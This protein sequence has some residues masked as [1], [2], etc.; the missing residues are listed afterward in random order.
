MR[1]FAAALIFFGVAASYAQTP[2]VPHKMD[3]AGMTLT[4]RDDARK[5]IQTD[6]DAL[7]RS[8]KHFNMKVERA[9]TYFPFIEK[10]FAEEKLPDDFK[11]LALQESALIADAVSV[12]NAVGFWQFKDFTAMEMGMRVDKEIDERMNLISASRGAAKYLKKNNN[13]FDNWL[14]ALQS[15]QMGA[16]GVQRSIGDKYNGS[17][18]MEITSET[19]WY[20]KKYLAHKV[21]FEAAMKGDAQLKVMDYQPNSSTSLS[22]VAKLLSIDEAKLIEY[23]KWARKGNIPDDR[24]YTLLVPIGDSDADFTKLALSKAPTEPAVTVKETKTTVVEAP[25][26]INGVA[27]IKAQKGELLAALASRANVDVTDFAKYNDISIDHHVKSGAYY[28]VDKKKTKASE[29]FHQ[30][31]QGEDL[32]AVSQKYGVQLRK[33]L[34]YNRV[35]ASAAVVAGT[36][37]WLAGKMP[38]NSGSEAAKSTADAVEVSDEDTFEWNTEAPVASVKKEVTISPS[39]PVEILETIQTTP[40]IEMATDPSGQDTIH[41]V[42]PKETL[43]SIAK[44]YAVSVGDLA[45]WNSLDL[46][47]GIHPGQSLQV[48]ANALPLPQ[49]GAEPVIVKETEP[50]VVQAA[51]VNNQFH[52]VKTSDT[53]Y[54]VARQ[55]GV[56]IKELM[57]WN[58]KTDFSLAVGEKLKVSGK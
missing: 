34:K 18:H 21:A 55:Y 16:G 44:M 8:P 1:F 41:I 39:K 10:I 14:L 2:E 45:Q 13:F 30:L 52:E 4:I 42:Q 43:Y 32:W 40:I 38:K 36:Q 6:V 47:K 9:R 27:T 53:L 15:Y 54:S 3:F 48:F 37:I 7:T 19:Y 5:E 35:D 22:D 20:V 51:I 17:R 28:F 46:Q 33:L 24:K 58:S 29:P 49:S 11:Y 26:L 57:D 25:F 50:V 12:S 23:N 31:Q 56:T